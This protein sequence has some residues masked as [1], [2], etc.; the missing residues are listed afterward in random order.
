MP[1]PVNSTAGS[2]FTAPILQGV[3]LADIVESNTEEWRTSR[4]CELL[5][6][7]RGTLDPFGCSVLADCL[8]DS[9][10]NVTGVLEL[11]RDIPGLVIPNK[12]DVVRVQILLAAMDR[13]HKFADS[14]L[15]GLISHYVKARW[16]EGRRAGKP[17]NSDFLD[18]WSNPTDADLLSYCTSWS[19]LCECTHM[20]MNRPE[21]ADYS[22]RYVFDILHRLRASGTLTAIWRIFELVGFDITTMC[23]TYK[24]WQRDREREREFNN[25]WSDQLAPAPRSPVFRMLWIDS[26]TSLLAGYASAPILL[27]GVE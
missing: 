6:R 15:T 22:Q 3:S 5:K 23:T 1:S 24:Q 18:R 17:T 8:E 26:P 9:G 7:V 27:T 25:S 12:D 2:Y 10:F 16:P 4:V 21:H 14:L 19:W 20:L 11:L 13:E